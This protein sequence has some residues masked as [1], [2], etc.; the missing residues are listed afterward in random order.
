VLVGAANIQPTARLGSCVGGEVHR[1]KQAS[2][3]RMQELKLF[4]GAATLYECKKCRTRFMCCL[5]QAGKCRA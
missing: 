2:E 1:L 3:E 4:Q 5:Q